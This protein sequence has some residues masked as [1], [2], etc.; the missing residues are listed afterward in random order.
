MIF[1]LPRQ[2]YSTIPP[3]A[4]KPLDKPASTSTPLDHTKSQD[5]NA[6]PSTEFKIPSPPPPPKSTAG[7][8][9]RF[10]S[11]MK[12]EVEALDEARKDPEG[13]K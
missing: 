8:V 9:E 5:S 4:P 6:P 11:N 12:K 2:S 3:N 13:D 1:C 10:S 7:F